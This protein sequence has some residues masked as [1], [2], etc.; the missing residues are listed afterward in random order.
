METYM[1]R[2]RVSMI[3]GL[4][5]LLIMH[6]QTAGAQNNGELS[7]GWRVLN[8]EEQTF[9][10]GWYADVLGNVTD[11]FGVVG[12]VAGHYKSFDESRFVSGIQVDVSA[13][14]RVHTFMGGA[15]YTLR[16]NPRITP[17]AQA[18]VGIAQASFDVEGSATVAGRTFTVDESDSASD[19]AVELG[20]GVNIGLTDGI[21]LRLAGSYFRIF[22]EDAS[23][24]FR[25]A[26][27]VVFPF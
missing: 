5:A 15:R 19:A 24:A 27:G 13:D 12:E 17:F 4:G 10:G 22:E 23:N 7:A 25:F 2:L 14:A 26:A 1:T 9:T 18:L 20:G 16:R 3:A 8:V 6:P 11:T 21:G